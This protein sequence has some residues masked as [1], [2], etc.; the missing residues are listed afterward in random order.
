MPDGAHLV[1][2]GFIYFIG[3]MTILFF[4]YVRRFLRGG[5]FTYH[6]PEP[7]PGDATHQS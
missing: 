2:S 4:V 1:L 7:Q 6:P 3:I 5:M